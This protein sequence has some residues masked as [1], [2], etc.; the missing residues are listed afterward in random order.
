M[1]P[2]HRPI[3]DPGPAAQSALARLLDAN[4][5]RAAEGLR[6]L[7]DL[8]RFALDDRE[9]STAAKALRH[10]LTAWLSTLETL[11]L[12][13]GAR[14]DARDAAGDAGASTGRP[15][16]RSTPAHI[17]AAAADRAAQALRVVEETALACG[18]SP[19]EPEAIRYA[20]YDLAASIERSLLAR[21]PQWRVCVLLTR[22]LCTHH[23]PMSVLRLAIEGGA[24]CVQIR[25]KDMTSRAL[26]AHARAVVELCR[27]AGVQAIVNDHAAIARLSGAHGVHVGRDDLSPADV[28]HV[29]GE[30]TL[31]GVSTTEPQEIAAAAAAGASY[32]GVGPMFAT[33]T[34]HKDRI[35]GPPA[36][37]RALSDIPLPHLAI[38]GISTGNIDELIGVG[39][40]GVALSAAVCGAT[41][42]AAVCRTIVDKLNAKAARTPPK[43]ES[44]AP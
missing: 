43:Q 25:E 24:D 13:R 10:R 44:I 22:S 20:T 11:G 27:E 39:C 32:V 9:R 30:H 23:E 6:T 16:P 37:E 7:E 42:P 26:L 14:L 33:T 3:Q 18:A 28:R 8:A 5:N 35:A 1:H 17:A 40:R 21:A 36:L 31:V 15:T 38:G 19:A 34:K 29:A 12:G 4:A 41:D 2:A